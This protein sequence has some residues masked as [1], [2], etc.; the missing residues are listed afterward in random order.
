MVKFPN[1]RVAMYYND[2]NSFDIEN[3]NVPFYTNIKINVMKVHGK[4]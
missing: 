4:S 1:F 3:I 2:Y